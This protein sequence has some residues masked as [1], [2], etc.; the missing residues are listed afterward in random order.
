M[1]VFLVE[2]SVDTWQ[3]CPLLMS[4]TDKPTGKVT[5]PS[6]DGDLD[7][8]FLDDLTPQF[9][10]TRG[11]PTPL[12][13]TLRRDGVNF[14]VFSKHA[15]SVALVLYLPGRQQPC[16]EFFLDAR[17]NRT[18]DIWHVLVK[19]IDSGI[20]YGWRVDGPSES[21]IHRF[22][23]GKVLVDPY[24]KALSVVPVPGLEHAEVGIAGGLVRA[25]RSI[26][27]D[28]EFDWGF[29]QPLN[30][31]LADT[32]VYEL[33]VRG[34]TCHETSGVDAPGTFLG[35]I[36]K[37][38]YLQDLGVTAVELMPINEFEE[39]DNPRTNPETG[40][41]LKNFWGY[42][43]I[44]FFSPNAGYAAG[45]GNGAQVDEF[46]T[47]VKAFHEA[48]I[49]VILDMVFNHTG[50]G[51]QRGPTLSF[52]GL[53]NEV[54]Y[55]LDGE[56]GDYHNYSGCGNT[57]NCNHPIVR[58]MILACLRYWVTEMHVD[59]FRFDLASIL[60]RGR[61]GSV[62]TN[63]PR[64]ERIAADPVLANTKLIAEAWDA[65][66]LYQ[67]GTFPNFGRW[68]EWNGKF[69]D[70]VRRFVKGDEGMVT[71]IA[72]R[73]TGSSDLYQPSGRAPFHSIN[74][75]TS[76][77]GFPLADL[78]SYNE[79][80]NEAN[81]ESNRDGDS[82]NNSWNCGVEGPTDSEEVL[83]LRRRQQK[84]FASILLLSQGVPM[85]LAGDEMGRTQYGNNNTYCHDNEINWINWDLGR[86][87]EDL[88]RFFKTLIH[89]RRECGLLRRR[90]FFEGSGSGAGIDWHGT[91]LN[92]P[93]WGS[94][95]R[96]VAM[97]LHGDGSEPDLYL[98]ANSYSEELEFD[99][100]RCSNG[101]RWHRFV[102]T[103]LPSP[104]DVVDPTQVPYLINQAHYTVRDRTV[105]VL[106]SQ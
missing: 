49:E 4:T 6:S 31:H 80:H 68:A 53:D 41:P 82:H 78:V 2:P 67:V 22:D 1:E 81:G 104:H 77:D 99:L 44:N 55:I 85:I 5:N 40:A 29:D 63:P 86:E 54:Y 66:G 30:R 39:Y 102:D 88:A 97:H 23:A 13:A 74:F 32:I 50:E 105:V 18:G 24:A 94:Q 79:K 106:L 52:R 62:L 83:E 9:E 92:Q 58:N 48:G 16:G 93:D 37:I 7:R 21:P 89:M 69:R 91:K 96:S 71:A 72:T 26:V 103:S 15:T 14:A 60:G 95:S 84:N 19:G 65:A 100:P 28:D 17:Y 12:G 10:I 70:D 46:K 73:L 87:N 47:M 34:F 90:T 3:C 43:P 11:H 38:P 61:D 57:L 101:R 35:L 76:H 42:H 33:H 20:E 27:V 45:G 51:D 36:E 25:R 75:V 8:E 56:T 64:V 59:G 98:I